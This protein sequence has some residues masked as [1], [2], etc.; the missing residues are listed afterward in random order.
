MPKPYDGSLDDIFQHQ[1]EQRD[2]A[3]SLFSLQLDRLIDLVKAGDNKLADQS[4]SA[5]LDVFT[6]A[7]ISNGRMLTSIQKIN[8]GFEE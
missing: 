1:Q 7:Q 6:R 5:I 3:V 4:K 2:I 8:A